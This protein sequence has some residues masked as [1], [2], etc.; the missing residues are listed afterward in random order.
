MPEERFVLL[1]LHELL[2]WLGQRGVLTILT[3][4]QHGLVTGDASAPVDVSYLADAVLLFRYFEAQAQVRKAIAAVKNRSGPHEKT[5]RELMLGADG[6]RVGP[7]LSEFNGVLTGIPEWAGA[8]GAAEHMRRGAV[9]VPVPPALANRIVVLAPSARDAPVT[10][11][12]LAKAGL[13]SVV[14]RDVAQACLLLD[15]GA[16]A[17]LVA[18]EVFAH[19]GGA[20][21]RDWLARQAPWSDLP[22]L[23]FTAAGAAAE[24]RSPALETL[25][26]HGNV[27]L[28]DRPVRVVTLLSSVRAALRVRE[29]QY[30]MRELLDELATSVRTRDQFLAM[31]GHEL[32]NPL[33]AILSATELLVRSP[34]DPERPAA[35]IARQTRKL[36]RLVDDLLEVSRVESGKIALQRSVT[37]LRGA[38]ERSLEGMAA[39]AERGGVQLDVA[40]PADP[41]PV[42]GDPMRLEQVVGN[43]VANAL[44]YTPAA[45]TVT[46]ELRVQDGRA[47]VRV[48][49][50]GI[51]I[52][53]DL[54]DEIFEP[55]TQAST[56]LDRSEGGLG[57]GLSLVRGLVALHG[58]DVRARSEGPGRGSEFLVELPLSAR[59]LEPVRAPAATRATVERQDG[60]ARRHVLVV[61]DNADNRETL[62]MLLESFGHDVVTASDGPSGVRVAIDAHPEVAIVDIGLPGFDGYEV[63]RRLREALGTS[64][65]LVALTGYGQA[66]DRDRARA[67]GFDVHLTKPADVETVAAVIERAG[68]LAHA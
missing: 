57:L 67:A 20:R 26:A 33:A 40:L 29:R 44:K 60:P 3:V 35:V 42:D 13:P 61:E 53:P 9:S 23:V 51:G 45:G 17:V 39:R 1:Q 7:A 11:S 28:L 46:V 65:T 54:L 62:V 18:E 14:A 21:L 63:G 50:T 2:T 34:S 49:D 27:A 24:A 22:V 55:F 31:L 16:A 64:V 12:I 5:I 38:V 19:G 37:D 68:Q 48:S 56:S 43:L 59:A 15:E 41:V 32:R 58:G 4:A 6:I 66:E 36:T 10:V 8:H 52:A 25:A 30:R 47:L